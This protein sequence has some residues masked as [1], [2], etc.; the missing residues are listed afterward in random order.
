LFGV[1]LF[2]GSVQDGRL[3]PLHQFCMGRLPSVE[4]WRLAHRWCTARMADNFGMA[5]L[6]V[7]DLSEQVYID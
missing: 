2:L 5:T 6:I 1:D 7:N 4:E 3:V